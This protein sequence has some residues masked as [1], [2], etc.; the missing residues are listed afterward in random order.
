M[1]IFSG[2]LS[3]ALVLTVATV[4]ATPLFGCGKKTSRADLGTD[5]AVPTSV[6]EPR[7]SPYKPRISPYIPI[8]AR[9]CS[10]NYGILKKLLQL[11]K[12]TKNIPILNISDPSVTL[13]P[14]RESKDIQ[15]SR[16]RDVFYKGEKIATLYQHEVQSSVM[17]S[18][19]AIFYN[20]QVIGFLSTYW[21]IDIEDR[22][23]EPIIQGHSI[24]CGYSLMVEKSNPKKVI[25]RIYGGIRGVT[26]YFGPYSLTDSCGNN[27]PNIKIKGRYLFL[28]KGKKPVAALDI[29]N[30][31]SDALFP[32]K[33]SNKGTLTQRKPTSKHP[34]HS[35]SWEINKTEE[36]I[37]KTSIK[38]AYGIEIIEES[39][40]FSIAQLKELYKILSKIPKEHL[41]AIK[42]I[43]Y[44]KDSEEALIPFAATANGNKKELTISEALYKYKK[45]YAKREKTIIHEVGHL[46]IETRD[47]Q[48]WSDA[49]N[50]Y[51]TPNWIKA[52]EQL[53]IVRWSSINGWEPDI[54][55]SL[56][57]DELIK[58]RAYGLSSM[59]HRMFEKWKYRKDGFVSKYAKTYPPE[60]FAEAYYFYLIR[61]SE[62]REMSRRKKTLQK[63]YELLK[64]DIFSGIEF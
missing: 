17:T 31:S 34:V 48:T 60:S 39:G 15:E 54:K 61:G 26:G 13:G 33:T 53:L 28:S 8:K 2:R 45:T 59:V 43:R 5:S 22:N 47:C 42:V 40:R 10:P 35:T 20:N 29:T 9:N 46:V 49:T 56:S 37:Y 27:V 57:S 36:N 55:R 44:V 50:Y 25:A 51:G 32:P 11:S 62:F 6:L 1:P 38:S 63:Q 21:K 24:P 3:R 18:N 14:I 12:K 52:L 16:E 4:L 30:V 19:K 58:R 7:I 23:G 41:N 64:T